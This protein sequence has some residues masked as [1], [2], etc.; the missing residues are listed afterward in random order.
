VI[1]ALQ[2]FDSAVSRARA[3]AAFVRDG[4]AAGDRVL[5][6][7]RLEDWTPAGER[8]L[9]Q[10]VAPE[11]A[12]ASGRLVLTDAEAMLAQMFER[13]TPGNAVQAAAKVNILCGYAAS[14]FPDAEALGT[15]R[16]IRRLH[17][18][19][20]LEPADVLSTQLLRA[21]GA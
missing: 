7:T 2:L 13:G 9:K 17:T 11:D 14:H 4:L 1:H 19:V 15:L 6:M 5:V 20:H 3:L 10:G 12:I 16:A 8:L 21:A 18:H